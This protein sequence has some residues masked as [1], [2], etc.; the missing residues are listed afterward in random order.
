MVISLFQLDH[1]IHQC[2]R[3]ILAAVDP[4]SSVWVRHV[5]LSPSAGT[6]LIC[7]DVPTL[8]ATPAVHQ[9]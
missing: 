3:D 6:D 2:F 1:G 8:I 5:F 4:E 7:A 9:L